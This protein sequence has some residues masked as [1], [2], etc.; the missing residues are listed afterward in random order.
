MLEE[1][2]KVAGYPYEVSNLG[3]VRAATSQVVL[4]QKTTDRGYKYVRLYG[5]GDRKYKSKKVHRLVLEA[6]VG[7]SKM[8]VNHRNADK[9]DNRLEN[10]EYCTRQANMTHA[11]L[12]GRTRNKYTGKLNGEILPEYRRE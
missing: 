6:F 11:K 8:E 2:R 10:L 3:R 4:S 12:L 7:P 5:T 9:T 1:W